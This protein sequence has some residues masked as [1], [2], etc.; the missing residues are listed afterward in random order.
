M[1]R[2]RFGINLCFLL[3]YTNYSNTTT[4]LKTCRKKIHDELTGHTLAMRKCTSHSLDFSFRS[5]LYQVQQTMSIDIRTRAR[6]CVIFLSWHPSQYLNHI[7]SSATT[8]LPE[9]GFGEIRRQRP[10]TLRRRMDEGVGRLGNN[11]ICLQCI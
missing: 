6:K 7:F 2:I 9:R 11:G 4:I 10:T 8:L 1:L 3:L 5:E